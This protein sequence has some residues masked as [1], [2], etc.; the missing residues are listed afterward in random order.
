[1]CCFFCSVGPNWS[2][3][4]TVF[5]PGTSQETAE[6][7]LALRKRRR[8]GW[9]TRNRYHRIINIIIIIVGKEGTKI[10]KQKREKILQEDNDVADDVLQL[11]IEL[12]KGEILDPCTLSG[13]CPFRFSFIYELR[14]CVAGMQRVRGSSASQFLDA[15]VRPACPVPAH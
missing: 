8:S 3:S 10:Q 2:Q 11:Q 1:M 12:P 6:M 5:G 15:P 9:T 7:Q 4:W 13:T 14:S